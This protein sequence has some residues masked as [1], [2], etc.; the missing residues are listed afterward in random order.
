MKR[1]DNMS[2]FETVYDFTNDWNE[3]SNAIK[4]QR[5][6][7]FKAKHTD[8]ERIDLVAAR[9]INK[10]G[11]VTTLEINTIYVFTGKISKNTK[12]ETMIKIEIEI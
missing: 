1:H 4:S 11:F 10:Y 7:V 8:N 9:L 5:E 2:C 6:I 3:R 12:V